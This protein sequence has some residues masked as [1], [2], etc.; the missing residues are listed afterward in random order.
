MKTASAN[1]PG[2]RQQSQFTCMAA[3]ISAALRAL[4]KPFTEE[5]VNKV[6]GAAPLRGARW[7]EAMATLQY[8]GCRGTLVV[9]ATLTMVKSWTDQGYPVLIAW[10]PEGRPWSHA[11][12]VADVSS[13][14]IVKV[15]DPNIP[16]PNKNFREV[17]TEEFYKKWGETIE[18]LM[19]VRRPAML[20][21]LEVDKNGRQ[22]VASQA[23]RSLDLGEFERYLKRGSGGI[24]DTG[25]LASEMAE[26][27]KSAKFPRGET[28]TIDEVAKVVGPEFKEMNVNPPE[29]VV[30]V[31]EEMTASKTASISDIKAAIKSGLHTGD[32]SKALKL[33]EDADMNDGEMYRMVLSVDSDVSKDAWADLKKGKTA[34]KPKQARVPSPPPM[35]MT[36]CDMATML[37]EEKEGKFEE[38]KPADPTQ[39]MS[40]EDAKEWWRQHSQNKDN[41]KAAAEADPLKELKSEFEAALA[42]ALDRFT[43]VQGKLEND[44]EKAKLTKDSMWMTLE[45]IIGFLEAVKKGS[46]NKL[47]Y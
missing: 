46:S 8:F 19:V 21:T 35:L 33:M 4:G 6:L 31:R 7:E 25:M 42:R 2:I 29:S 41:F 38:G 44:I 45:D 1:V 36:A 16:D 23:T 27:L 18:D 37:A 47:T 34:S 9:P 43:G 17:L 40:P 30:Q 24:M 10:N 15:M 3:S 20:V 39:N 22:V 13:T 12:V 28:M 32:I 5:D 14:G 11:S 26:I